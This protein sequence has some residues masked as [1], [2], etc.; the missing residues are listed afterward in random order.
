M[1]ILK[2]EELSL[3]KAQKIF[4]FFDKS[5][6]IE[7]LSFI[8]EGNESKTLELYRKIYDQGVDPKVFINDFLELLYYFKN[9]DSL[10]IENTNF[11]LNDDEFNEIKMISKK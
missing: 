4:G 8:F 6:L 9:I 5:K 10:T 7:L 3:D 1:S 2:N 11:S